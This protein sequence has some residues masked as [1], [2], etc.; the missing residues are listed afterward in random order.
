MSAPT[1]EILTIGTEILLG[2]IVDTNTASIASAL[3]ETGINL[4]RTT[5]VG[6]NRARIAAAL[7]RSMKNSEIV[8]TTG[9]LGPTEDDVTRAAIADALEVEVEFRSEL[10][11]QIQER[12]SRFGRAPTE[13]N[14]RQ[15]YVP[16]GADAIEN[17]V[18][19]APAFT[20]EADDSLIIALPGVPAEMEF[21]L[22]T[23]VLPSLRRRFRLESEIETR[24]VRVVGMGESAV[25]AKIQ[26]LE[27]LSN[28]TVGVSAHPGR[29]DLRLAVGAGEAS[30]TLD[31]LEAELRDRL[32]EA[33]YGVDDETLERVALRAVSERGWSLMTLDVGTDGALAAALSPVGGPFVEGLVLPGGLRAEEA[34]QRLEEELDASPADVGLILLQRQEDQRTALDIHLRWAGG[35]AS[36]DRTYGGPPTRAAQWGVSLALDLL[37]RSLK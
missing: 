1:A 35:R 9:G 34:E 5:T 23:E 25:D 30:A 33:V 32:G 19:T 13:N 12:Y 31:E 29:V 24:V 28:P 27:A 6:D 37:R 20:V 21:L 17:P 22:E 3:R 11:E 26:D 15:A 10:W 8:I 18:G 4:Y 36:V 14:R 16:V 7:Q 2:Q